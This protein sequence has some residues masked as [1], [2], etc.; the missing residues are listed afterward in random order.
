MIS[1]NITT[2]LKRSAKMGFLASMRAQSY[3]W[4]QVAST[5]NMDERTID[6]VDLGAAPMPVND[7][8][9]AQDYIE[10]TIQV[11]A[12]EWITKVWIYII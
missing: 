12:K 3:P 1:G 11:S 5:L 6:L 2:A 8:S 7:P 10:K 9:V 4:Q